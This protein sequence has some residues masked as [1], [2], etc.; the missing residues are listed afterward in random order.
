MA[1]PCLD[2]LVF[3][4][5][6]LKGALFL[7]SMILYGLLLNVRGFQSQVESSWLPLGPGLGCSLKIVAEKHLAL[8]DFAGSSA[9]GPWQ[10]L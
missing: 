5:P 9:G 2:G 1:G 8:A 4:F 10:R 6:I 3:H 7:P